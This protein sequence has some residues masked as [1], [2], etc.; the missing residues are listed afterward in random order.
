MLQ[1]RS[2]SD[3]PDLLVLARSEEL[4]HVDGVGGLQARDPVARDVV[5]DADPK[6]RA[7]KLEYAAILVKS[8]MLMRFQQHLQEICQILQFFYQILSRLQK[9]SEMIL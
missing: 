2:L 5:E 7:S 9:F 1:G 8:A 3:L 6:P 4:F